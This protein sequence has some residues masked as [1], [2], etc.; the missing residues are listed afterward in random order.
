MMSPHR[1][2]LPAR[3]TDRPGSAAAKRPRQPLRPPVRLTRFLLSLCL[4]PMLARAAAP[5][6]NDTLRTAAHPDSGK[7]SI[8]PWYRSD[9]TLTTG[10]A[11]GH[12]GEL[13]NDQF[14]AF[15]HFDRGSVGLPANGML[16]SGAPQ[17]LQLL[18]NDLHLQDPLSG[19][20]D[21]NLI[22][23]LA[24]G[25]VQ[26]FPAAAA[27]PLPFLA[28]SQTLRLV[29][30]DMAAFPLRSRAAYRSGGNGYDDIDFR[31][32]L[33]YSQRLRL[34]AGAILKNYAGT[35]SFHEKY[36]AQKV[37][38]AVQR[39]FGAQWQVQYNLLYNISDLDLP[40]HEPVAAQPALQ[41]PHHKEA[42]FDH[43]LSIHFAQH[44]RAAVQ[45][46]DLHRERYGH[47]HRV[48]SETQDVQR[49]RLQS[50]WLWR[51]RGLTGRSG[52]AWQKTS[53]KSRSWG[54]HH[55]ALLDL[56]TAL[57]WQPAEGT[58]ASATLDWRRLPEGES[59]L[60]PQ[61]HIRKTLAA[62]W[63]ALAWYE[64]D[65]TAPPMAACYEQSPF[66]V[67]S[68]NLSAQTADHLGAGLQYRDAGGSRLFLALSASRIDGAYAIA[69]EPLSETGAWINLPQQRR[70]SL[71]ITFAK[72]WTRWLSL[73][74]K[75]KQI[76]LS[77]HEALQQPATFAGGNITLHRVFFAGDLDARLH[78][79]CDLWSRRTGPIPF[80]VDTSPLRE[81]LGAAAIP[82]LHAVGIIRDV[83]LFFALQN[84]L[85][86][87]YEVVRAYPMPRQQMR[88]GLVW[89]FYD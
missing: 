33:R 79:G 18:W 64:R 5:A 70:I 36:R 52:A 63:Q 77:G 54:D 16:F 68:Q 80:Y 12:A 7:S 9:S 51:W 34:Q 59:G 14:P 87:D 11:H 69:W 43:G 3:Q 83:T 4:L 40:L 10:A 19:A 22:P 31:A 85:G 35:S 76:A 29:H 8:A 45:L 61:L 13:L 17:T 24:I 44:W 25:E 74:A 1:L 67:G 15:Y 21:L 55:D 6:A 49:L 57:D 65:L 82:W 66:A 62:H 39:D 89:H 84:P 81:T 32:G 28:A 41:Q 47:R 27:T 58:T 75:I 71:D 2:P 30:H 56:W 23:L 53:L 42:R 20:S 38:V 86:I 73:T 48:W 60:N 50:E 78:I 37:N 46:T 26:L 88:W 72:P